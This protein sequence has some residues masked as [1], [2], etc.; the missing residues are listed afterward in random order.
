MIFLERTHIQYTLIFLFLIPA[1]FLV[2]GVVQK[3]HIAI[4]RGGV[5]GIVYMMFLGGGKILYVTQFF[6]Q[7][8]HFW[9]HL[10]LFPF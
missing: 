1:I 5:A 2:Q 4:R 3:S 7:I 6:L 8:F 9:L 10:I